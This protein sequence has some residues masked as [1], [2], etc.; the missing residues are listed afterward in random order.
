M[1]FV[2]STEIQTYALV[3]ATQA[4][5][6]EVQNVILPQM[7]A[8]AKSAFQSAAKDYLSSQRASIYLLEKRSYPKRRQEKHWLTP[9][10]K[11]LSMVLVQQRKLPRK[12]RRS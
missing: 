3:K 11:P 7:Q 8:V 2:A 12:R 9:K 1:R 5:S 4:V 10:K 6:D